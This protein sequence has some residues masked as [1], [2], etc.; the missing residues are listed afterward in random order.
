MKDIRISIRLSEGE[1]MALKMLA[2]KKKQPM[3][4][5]LHKSVVNMINKDNKHAKN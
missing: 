2:I 4:T 5:L 3:Q 1:H